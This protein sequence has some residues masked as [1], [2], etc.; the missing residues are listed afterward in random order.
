MGVGKYA[1]PKY[2]AK[3]AVNWERTEAQAKQASVGVIGALFI[4]ALILG[5]IVI[6]VMWPLSLVGHAIHLTPNFPQLMRHDHAWEHQHYP[7]I[8]LRY[9][10]VVALIAAIGVGMVFGMTRLNRSAS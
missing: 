4:G 10:L 2:Y 6:A 9:L 3:R 7:L 8:F 5:A 1:H